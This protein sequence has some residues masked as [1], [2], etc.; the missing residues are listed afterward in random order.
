MSEGLSRRDLLKAAG[1]AGTAALVPLAPA[2]AQ[3]VVEVEAIEPGSPPPVDDT[4]FF[5]N[6]DEARF[7][8]AAIDRLIPP[9]PE[10]TGAAGA[11]VLYYIDRQLASDYGGGGRMYLDGPW[12]PEAPSQHGYQLRQSPGELYRIGI[13]E[14]RG[15]ARGQHNEQEFWDLS[16][17][18]MDAVLSAIETGE[19]QLPSIPGPVFFETLLANTIE[20]FFA[21]PAYGGNRDM[22]G[23]KMIGFPGA[24]ASYI[25][26]IEQ[27]NVA[28]VRP[29]LS[30]ADRAAR[31]AHIHVHDHGAT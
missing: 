25:D 8:T 9:D 23:W 6:D 13:A 29:P 19:A 2:S 11:G 22:V 15:Y 31:D 1:L 21:D 7:V 12:V 17:A 10:W 20:G 5:F 28:Y 16:P 3:E 24:Y 14:V 4:L 26:L 30:F 18:A 27:Y